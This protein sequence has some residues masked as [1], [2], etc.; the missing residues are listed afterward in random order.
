MQPRKQQCCIWRDSIKPSLRISYFCV[1]FVSK[2]N[3]FWLLLY[4]VDVLMSYG[5]HI[6]AELFV[7]QGQ[8]QD[9][10]RGMSA[11]KTSFKPHWP[12]IYWVYYAF[13]RYR[14]I[15]TIQIYLFSL[16]MSQVPG[17]IERTLYDASI[18]LVSTIWSTFQWGPSVGVCEKKSLDSKFYC[19]PIP[20]LMPEEVISV[21]ALYISRYRTS[22]NLICNSPIFVWRSPKA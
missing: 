8:Y 1:F 7:Q 2:G 14:K 9:L 6:R 10:G 5:L 12:T 20:D 17:Y 11:R 13:Q 4:C 16:S 22:S 18:C 19:F 21:C 15:R 3:P